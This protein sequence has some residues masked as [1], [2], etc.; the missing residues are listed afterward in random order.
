V[1][2]PYEPYA[3]YL[4]LIAW[5]YSRDFWHSIVSLE[6]SLAIAC[7]FAF[8]IR[9]AWPKMSESDKLAFENHATGSHGRNP[10]DE[11]P[12][13]EDLDPLKPFLTTSSLTE[14]CD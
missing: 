11:R 6:S 13:G 10:I 4:Y 1:Q 7:W 9:Q 3:S 8:K 12:V 2:V 14:S 5:P